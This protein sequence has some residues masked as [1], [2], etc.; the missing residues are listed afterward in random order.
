MAKA[1]PA[2]PPNEAKGRGCEG[3]GTGL[4]GPPKYVKYWPF[5]LYLGV[6]GHY[7]TYFG[8][9]GIGNRLVIRVARAWGLARCFRTRG[10]SKWFRIQG[11]IV[12]EITGNPIKC[13]FVL[14]TNVRA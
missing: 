11:F 3:C 8:G 1:P 2:T 13:V 7:F 9:L 5:G 4:P 12:Y 10:E 14:A 6:L